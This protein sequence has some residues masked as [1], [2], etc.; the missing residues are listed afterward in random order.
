MNKKLYHVVGQ[1]ATGDVF[2]L[3]GTAEKYS[4]T[5]GM[6][7][8]IIMYLKKNNLVLDNGNG[9]YVVNASEKDIVKAARAEGSKVEYI[10]PEMI[11]ELA[12]ELTQEDCFLLS[13]LLQYSDNPVIY[14]RSAGSRYTY[15]ERFRMQELMDKYGLVHIDKENN[16]YEVCYTK[17]FV[18]SLRFA[19]N[20][21]RAKQREKEREKQEVVYKSLEDVN[22][23][24]ISLEVKTEN[25]PSPGCYN[26]YSWI[27]FDENFVFL[28]DK[29]LSNVLAFKSVFYGTKATKSYS[30][31][32]INWDKSKFYV[33]NDGKAIKS[34]DSFFD[35]FKERED[36]LV[37]IANKGRIAKLSCTLVINKKYL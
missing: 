21:W 32:Y 31:S 36:E 2:T 35:A 3:H 17:N 10:S 11:V 19:I 18:S 29:V 33:W 25:T 9:E 24:K 34:T 37:D 16:T 7:F 6:A 20:E 4:C 5:L 28:L 26:F 1:I 12:T 14:S 23:I 8:D 15:K 30:A 13:K 27:K 22:R